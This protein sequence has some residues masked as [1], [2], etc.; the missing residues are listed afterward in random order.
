MFF[1]VVLVLLKFLIKRSYAF[2]IDLHISVIAD[3]K[4]IFESLGHE[5]ESKSLSGHTWVFEKPQ[6]ENQSN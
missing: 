5:V 6:D 1:L 3:L 4:N 2:N